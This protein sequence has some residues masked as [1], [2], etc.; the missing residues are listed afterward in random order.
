MIISITTIKGV[1][2]TNR[3]QINSIYANLYQNQYQ[4]WNNT[5]KMLSSILI[6]AGIVAIFIAFYLYQC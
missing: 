6:E 2:N 4:Q 3:Q 5:K 1:V